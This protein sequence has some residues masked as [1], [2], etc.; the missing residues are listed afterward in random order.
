MTKQKAWFKINPSG[1]N[2]TPQTVEGWWILIF[3]I[4][5]IGVFAYLFRTYQF[6]IITY[7]IIIIASII[8]LVKFISNNCEGCWLW[9][10]NQEG[11]CK[12]NK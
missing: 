10:K 3:Y 8:F 1:L 11:Q 12:I 4:I 6:S 5:F 7:L 2:A 9:Q